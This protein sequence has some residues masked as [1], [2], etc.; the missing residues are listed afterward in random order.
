[1]QV[2]MQVNH[3]QYVV[4]LV[5]GLVAALSPL[6]GVKCRLGYLSTPCPNDQLLECPDKQT[7][8]DL[9]RPHGLKVLVGL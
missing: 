9:V 6:A 5:G 1:M 4:I 3:L 8:R 7:E 2:F